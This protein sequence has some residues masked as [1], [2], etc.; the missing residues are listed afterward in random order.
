MGKGKFALGR[1]LARYLDKR[2]HQHGPIPAYSA[3]QLLAVLR[4]GDVFLLEGNRRVSTAIKYL[5]QST[6]SH[7][8]LFIGTAHNLALPTG[9]CLIESDTQE[10]VRTVSIQAY[11]GLNTRICRPVGLTEEDCQRVIDHAIARLGHQY[12][13]CNFW[14]LARYLI[15]TPPVPQAYRRRMIALG[16]GDP[17]RAICST[18]IA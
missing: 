8:A 9:H 18:L 4:P 16:S 12:D 1:L 2:T 15:A 5:T 7:A 14:D 3:E 6:W 17:S 13:L 10:G 11:Q